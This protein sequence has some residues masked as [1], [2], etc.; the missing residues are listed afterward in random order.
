MAGTSGNSFNGSYRV[1]ALPAAGT[2]PLRKYLLTSFSKVR[3]WL[4]VCFVSRFLMFASLSNPRRTEISQPDNVLTFASYC[5]QEQLTSPSGSF[6]IRVTLDVMDL[7]CVSKEH[8]AA[9]SA[10]SSEAKRTASELSSSQPECSVRV[11]MT[12]LCK[13]QTFGNR[14]SRATQAQQERKRFCQSNEQLFCEAFICHALFR[15]R[16][17]VYINGYFVFRVR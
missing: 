10:W 6:H 7:C 14:P 12:R 9:K 3:N 11:D 15:Q 16:C 5:R 2:C 1:Q 4:A 8:L 17:F 13:E